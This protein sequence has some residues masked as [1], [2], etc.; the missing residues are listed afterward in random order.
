MVNG[1]QLSGSALGRPR[2]DGARD[3]AQHYRNECERVEV[4]RRFSLA[5]HNCGMG[6]VAARLRETATYMI[7]ISV[8]VLIFLKIQCA[9]LLMLE[10]LMV[11]SLPRKNGFSRNNCS[12]FSEV[13]RNVL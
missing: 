5:K 4:G 10:F 11:D 7:A 1:I 12:F 13:Y 3:K 9:I 8:L 2:K 6:P